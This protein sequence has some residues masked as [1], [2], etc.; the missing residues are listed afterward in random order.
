MKSLL[1]ILIFVPQFVICQVGVGTTSPQETLH[2]EG[3]M[4]ITNTNPSTA[5][6][7]MGMDA[8]GTVNE[9]TIGSNLTLNAGVLDAATGGN[10]KYLIATENFTTTSPGQ[11]FDDVDLEL[12]TTNNDIVVFRLMGASNNYDITG[13]AGGTDGRHIILLNTTA[14]NCK[15]I[16]EDTGSL[17]QN[18]IVT[19]AGG[20]ESTSG[21]GIAELVYDGVLQRWV[22][23]NFRD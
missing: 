22:I 18:R 5:T 2:V 12:N 8:N 7:L 23:I 19:L 16:E 15:L 20:F 11:D 10:T 17:A 21:T 14:N 6:G 9:V 13:I 1:L 3:S 4:R